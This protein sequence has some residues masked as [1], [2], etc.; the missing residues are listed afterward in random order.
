MRPSR[1][2]AATLLALALSTMSARAED[3]PPTGPSPCVQECA[4]AARAAA[5]TC[6]AG[7]GTLEACRQAAEAQYLQCTAGCPS[8]PPPTT[9]GTPCLEQCGAQAQQAFQACRAQGG[10]VESCTEAAKAGYLQCAA[11]NCANQA[12]PTC[13]ARCTA[14][15]DGLQ[16]HC[17]DE[18]NDADKCATVRQSALDR[19][20]QEMCNPTAETPPVVPTCPRLLGPPTSA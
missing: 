20:T 13:E 4:T 10:T 15:A 18:G 16:Q 1:V 5:E 9:G 17:L 8:A 11:A 19:C 2:F 12:P 14:L 7:G 6:Q 3:P